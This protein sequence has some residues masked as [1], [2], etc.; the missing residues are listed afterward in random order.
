[1]IAPNRK[2]H[3]VPQ[4]RTTSHPNPRP[5]HQP[6]LLKTMMQIVGTG[7]SLNDPAFAGQKAVKCD[8]SHFRHFLQS[9]TS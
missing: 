8:S 7:I 9:P 2:F 5:G 6:E 1:M 4:R 3:R